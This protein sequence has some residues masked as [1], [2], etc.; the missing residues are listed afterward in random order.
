MLLTVI[1]P[2]KQPGMERM[3]QKELIGIETEIIKN[4]W[5]VGLR[6]AKGSYVC[7]L[8]KNSAVSPETIR[9]NL[10]VFT[11]KPAYRKLAMV[12]SC[13]DSPRLKT[14]VSFTFNEGGLALMPFP[15]S[16]ETHAARIGYAPG[17]VIRTSSLR[18]FKHKLKI[19]PH[20]LSALLSVFFWEN[21]LRV[22]LNPDSLYYAPEKVIY[23]KSRLKAH[24]SEQVWYAWER[25]MIS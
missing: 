8:E 9:K 18:K 23:K 16:E 12:S 5:D 2:D 15:A 24:P 7:L 13:V 22:E 3:L 11:S 21:G 20:A 25:E 19:H 10:E 6:K 4:S 1:V 17:S 14:P